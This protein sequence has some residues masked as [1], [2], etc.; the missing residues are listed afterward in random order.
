METRTLGHEGP[1]VSAIGLGMAAIGRPG[2]LN[3]G[4]GRDLPDDPS[5]SRL[6]AHAHTVL[7]HAYAAGVRYLDV[8]RSYGRAEAFL[9]DWLDADPDRADQV[10]VGSKWGYTYTAAWRV[11]ARVHEV[12]DHGRATLDR[13]L[14]ETR[15]LLGDR[16][17]VHHIHSATLETGVLEDRLVLA[18]LREAKDRGLI[19]GLSLSG[20]QQR[21]T[22]ER[23]LELTAAGRAPFA[24]VQATWNVLEPSVGPALAAAAD[25]GWGVIV[26]EGVANGRLAPGDRSP[27]LSPPAALRSVAAAHGTS[28]DAVALA[29]ILAQP[30][31]SVVLSG[32]STPAQLTSNLDAL[33]VRLSGDDLE[34]LGQLAEPAERYWAT[35][36]ALPWN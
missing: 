19:V 18:G 17:T 14:A 32:A 3:L 31:T 24:C 6:R 7:D 35:R 26:K 25:A 36:G 30:F 13:Q 28:V 16:L 2:Y 8:A 22:L 9:A 12:K 1:A 21:Q 5:V 20:P 34:V 11:D 29:A 33:A 15:E 23:A 27:D 4:H 10:V